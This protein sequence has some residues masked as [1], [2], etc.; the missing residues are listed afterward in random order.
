MSSNNC[1]KKTISYNYSEIAIL[2]SVLSNV[3]QY[4][5]SLSLLKIVQYNYKHEFQLKVPK[6]TTNIS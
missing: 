6:N 3:I 2:A 5:A 1:E 4:S